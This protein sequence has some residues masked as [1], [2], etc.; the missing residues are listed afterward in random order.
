VIAMKKLLGLALVADG[1]SA[2]LI[3]ESYLKRWSSGPEWYRQAAKPFAE[4]PEATRAIG[5][6]EVTLGL[7]TLRRGRRKSS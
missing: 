5:L 3:P 1:A 7:W 4:H 6:T 2:V